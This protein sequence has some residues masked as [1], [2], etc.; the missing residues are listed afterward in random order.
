MS[1][2]RKNCKTTNR[3]NLRM[4]V[5]RLEQRNLFASLASGDF[6]GDGFDDTAAGV[7]YESFGAVVEGGAINVINGSA[8]GL[9][10]TGNQFWNQNSPGIVGNANS[11]ERFGFAI[12]TGDFN[13]DG[14]DDIAVGIP[15][16]LVG[17]TSDAGSVQVFYG[18][19]TGLTATG[20][21]LWNQNSPSIPGASGASDNF[22]YSLATGDFD[23]DGF[24]DLA[25]GAPG[26][27]IGA[28]LRA[29]S[30]TVL[31]GSATGLSSSGVQFWSQNSAGIIGVSQDF[32]VFGSSLIAG[33]FNQDGKD[34][35][36]IG[37]PGDWVGVIRAG[38]VNVLF[39]SATG[40]ASTGNQ[41]WS[42]N[43]AGIAD[44]AEDF[45]AFGTELASGDFDGD[46]FDDLAIG[47]PSEGLGV[48]GSAGAVH[49]I[50]GG[51]D[52]DSKRLPVA[53]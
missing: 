33:D 13:N 41:I 7:V 8:S 36:A 5:E 26:D 31:R 23:G 46:L 18:S 22:G 52:G 24:A 45:D 51:C 4:N 48:F 38:T 34:D 30:V 29:G 53:F 49:I 12:A 43:S 47:V 21:Q 3:S 32:D 20:N 40:L 19:S 16:D 25:I 2:P 11:F 27:G 6:N 9:V 14:R 44:V 15:N 17:V 35:L 42:Q 10:A 50:R 39:G 1:R 28:V 37:V